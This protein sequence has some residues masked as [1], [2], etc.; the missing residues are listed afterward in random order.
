MWATGENNYGQL[1]L[2]SLEKRW[3]FVK[4][5]IS[6]VKSVAVGY[7]HSVVLKRDGSVLTA[8]SN[9]Y[10]EL[11]DGSKSSSNKFEVVVPSGVYAV[12]AGGYHSFI[13]KRDGTLQGTGNNDNGQL[14]CGSTDKYKTGFVTA[15]K[16]APISM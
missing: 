11:G 13:L 4:V 12:G 5:P 10:G 1:G 8:G 3:E 7:Q 2:Q 15:H 6:D 14:G 9:K 16:L